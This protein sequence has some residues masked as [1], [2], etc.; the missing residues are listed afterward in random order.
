MSL[1]LPAIKFARIIQIFSQEMSIAIINSGG[2]VFKYVGD[3]LIAFFPVEHAKQAAENA[4][5]CAKAMTEA[6]TKYINPSFQIYGLPDVVKVAF[7][8]GNVLVVPYGK[9][10]KTSHVDILD[11]TISIVAKMLPYANRRIS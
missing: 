7:E 2:Y 8:Y 4:I 1:T 6:F 3:A 9:R 5:G 10:S 11:A